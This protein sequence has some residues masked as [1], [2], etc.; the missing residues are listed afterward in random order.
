MQSNTARADKP[1]ASPFG[2]D[3]DLSASAKPGALHGLVPRKDHEAE[4]A[5]ARAEARNAS[6]AEAAAATE[7]RTAEAAARIAESAER[8]LA[9]ADRECE[10]LRRDASMLAIAAAKSIAG[11]LIDKQPL[12]EIE[13]LIEACLAPLR[14]APQLVVRLRSAEAD[15]LRE[16]LGVIAERA[17]FNGRLVVIGEENFQPGDCRIEWADGGIMRD[18]NR[19]I[20]AI[21]S[22]VAR[23][24]AAVG[25]IPAPAP[26]PQGEP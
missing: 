21:E 22:T 13:S 9:L 12:S 15:A 3:L 17:G 4:L 16:R 1:K 24:F 10:T 23:H 18:R 14:S 26:P 8:L 2:F 19:A 7:A 6:L 20:A 5:R 25:G 11:T